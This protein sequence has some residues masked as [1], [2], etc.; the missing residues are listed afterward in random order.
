MSLC[1]SSHW[2]HASFSQ[3]RIAYN[4]IDQLYYQQQQAYWIPIAA[5]TG[6]GTIQT[7][8]SST[9]AAIPVSDTPDNVFVVLNDP[10]F[11]G[12]EML[13]SYTDS[14]YMTDGH[15]SSEQAYQARSIFVFFLHPDFSMADLRPSRAV[16]SRRPSWRLTERHIQ[17][18]TWPGPNISRQPNLST[19]QIALTGCNGNKGTG[20]TVSSTIIRC[21]WHPAHHLST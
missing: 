14:T 7:I 5:L 17:T 6:D 16:D 13:P 15:L 2:D 11:T 10:T 4:R 19:T 8:D 9:L 20:R 12:I 21:H 3:A 1:T 18:L